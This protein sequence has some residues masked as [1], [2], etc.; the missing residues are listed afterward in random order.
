MIDW[1]TRPQKLANVDPIQKQTRNAVW[2]VNF[3]IHTCAAIAVAYLVIA[4]AMSASA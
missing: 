2:W 3:T 4:I 1:S